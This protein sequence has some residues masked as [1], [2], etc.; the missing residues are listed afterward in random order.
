MMHYNI[1]SSTYPTIV[2]T[3]KKVFVPSDIQPYTEE[4][5]GNSRS[6]YIYSITVY[7]KD[8]YIEKIISDNTTTLSTLEE[9][10]QAAKILLGVE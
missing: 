10:L 9:E 6:G 8:E 2:I 4:E 5:D 1:K 3:E 7:D